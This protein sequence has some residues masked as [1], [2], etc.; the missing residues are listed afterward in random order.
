MTWHYSKNGQSLGPV[1]AAVLGKL[2]QVGELGGNNLLWRE[3]WAEWRVLGQVEE[4]AQFLNSSRPLAPPPLPGHTSDAT[5]LVATAT[6][7]RTFGEIEFVWCAPGTFV[8]GTPGDTQIEIPHQVTLTRGFWIG[9][10]PVTQGQWIRV[11]GSNPSD[12]HSAGHD[13]PVENVSWED[14]QAFC[15]TVSRAEGIQFRLPTEA[16]WEYACRAGSAGPYCFPGDLVDY[17]WYAEN[18][19]GTTHPVG[20]KRPNAWGLFDMHGNVWE[21]CADWY[22]NYTKGPTTDPMGPRSGS[23]RVNR[24]GGWRDIAAYCRSAYHN[25]DSPGVLG[26]D[27]GFRVAVSSTP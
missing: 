23:L 22:E 10:Y 4:F 27:L 17:A 21:W 19:N 24:G 13:A 12:F 6:E 26:D 25:G 7:T 2:I 5:E 15:S 20:Q 18:S 16:E 9:K 1:D 14:A 3:G 8:M 11:M